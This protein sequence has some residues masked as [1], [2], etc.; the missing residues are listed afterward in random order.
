METIGMSATAVFALG[1]IGA[2]ILTAIG[3]LAVALRRPSTDQATG[4]PETQTAPT[5]HA[6]PVFTPSTTAADRF[7]AVDTDLMGETPAAM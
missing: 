1:I 5:T 7:A 6:E 3:I 2:G 4:G